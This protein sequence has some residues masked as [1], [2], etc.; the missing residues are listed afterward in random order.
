MVVSETPASFWDLLLC[1]P[2]ETYSSLWVRNSPNLTVFQPEDGGGNS[3][4]NIGKFL[5]NFIVLDD[6]DWAVLKKP[7]GR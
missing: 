2:V 4:R 3:L 5:I 6:F 1:M 7:L